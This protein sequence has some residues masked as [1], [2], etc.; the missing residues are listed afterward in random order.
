MADCEEWIRSFSTPFFK[1]KLFKRS[2]GKE[3]YVWKRRVPSEDLVRTNPTD[4]VFMELKEY[5]EETSRNGWKVYER[6]LALRIKPMQR[7]GTTPSALGTE[8]IL[9]TCALFVAS[10]NNKQMNLLGSLAQ[11][12]CLQTH[13][14]SHGNEREIYGIL[15]SQLV[16][17]GHAQV[18]RGEQG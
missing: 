7:R 17:V 2:F 3:G 14:T 4:D 9:T 18:Q 15:Q 10:I 5:Q 1:F 11:G 12:S 13:A 6:I 16:R 8:Q